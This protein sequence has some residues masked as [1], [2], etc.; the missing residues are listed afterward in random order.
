M[1]IKRIKNNKDLQ[2]Y[3]KQND[4]TISVIERPTQTKIRQVINKKKNIIII[5]EED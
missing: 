3:L 1:N 4:M 5:T 2:Q